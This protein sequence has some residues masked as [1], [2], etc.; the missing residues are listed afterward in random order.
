[1]TYWSGLN[2]RAQGT[3][4][5]KE[6][7]IHDKEALIS[8]LEGKAPLSSILERIDKSL[9]TGLISIT[10]EKKLLDEDKKLLLEVCV[11]LPFLLGQFERLEDVLTHHKVRVII[12]PGIPKRAIPF[13]LEDDEEKEILIKMPLRGLYDGAQKVIKL[14]PEEMEMKCA[15]FVGRVNN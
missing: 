4:F 5:R 10:D 9:A 15:P 3:L 13:E 14:F 12:E 2:R 1:M 7:M 8:A 6:E 11:L